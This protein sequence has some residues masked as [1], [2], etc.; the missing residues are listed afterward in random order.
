MEKISIV[1][2]P[3]SFELLQ[4]HAGGGLFKNPPVYKSGKYFIDVD[5]EVIQAMNKYRIKNKLKNFDEV[6]QKI[7]LQHEQEAN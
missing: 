6:I 3:E 5:N 7:V 2:S 1:V 4:R